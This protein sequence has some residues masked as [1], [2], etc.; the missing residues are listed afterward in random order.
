[1]QAYLKDN[2]RGLGADSSKK[3]FLPV[4]ENESSGKSERVGIPN[5]HVFWFLANESLIIV[6]EINYAS[7]IVET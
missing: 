2:K 6:C 3:I 4:S 1:M 5:L 7:E